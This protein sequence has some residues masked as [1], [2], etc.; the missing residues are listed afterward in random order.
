M[1]MYVK[2]QQLYKR[3]KTE[4]TR[5]W[6]NQL[7]KRSNY[8]KYG[9]TNLQIKN[10]VESQLKQF[11]AA[12][13]KKGGGTLLEKTVKKLLQRSSCSKFIAIGIL[14]TVILLLGTCYYLF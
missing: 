14:Y 5:K 6:A 2:D 1:K 7:L 13:D 9:L 11:R 3:K 4:M 8:K 10:Y 12:M